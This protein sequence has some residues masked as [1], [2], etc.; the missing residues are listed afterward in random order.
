MDAP[1]PDGAGGVASVLGIAIEAIVA[2]AAEKNV[3]AA[4]S[5]A[6]DRRL[7]PRSGCRR[8]PLHPGCRCRPRHLFLPPTG[9]QQP[10]FRRAEVMKGTSSQ[11]R[12]ERVARPAGRCHLPPINK[13]CLCW[14]PGAPSPL[15]SSAPSLPKSRSGPPP[16]K[17]RCRRPEAPTVRRWRTAVDEVR[18]R[19]RH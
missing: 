11:M 6:A 15:S 1:V 3:I 4:T 13:S 9:V 8:R 10:T 19:S 7:R 16:P 12:H 5:G 18:C 14:G 2:L 17:N